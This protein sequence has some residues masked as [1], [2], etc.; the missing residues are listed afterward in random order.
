VS[1]ENV[2]I[3]RRLNA[4]FEEG[5]LEEAL[6]LID[7]DVRFRDLQGAPDVPHEVRGRDAV[8]SVWAQWA[9]AYDDFGA[10]ALAYVDAGAWVV[11]DVRW[12]G[13]GRGSGLRVDTRGADACRI[14]DGKVVEWILGY[15]DLQ[16]ALEDVGRGGPGRS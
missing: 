5:D 3:V 2:E 1:E 13:T 8:G 11:I 15:P 14:E 9:S 6:A 12:R 16:T 4:L 7:P 10:E